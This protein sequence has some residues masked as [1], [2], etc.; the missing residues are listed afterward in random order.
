M[1][2]EFVFPSRKSKGSYSAY[3]AYV[4]N[5]P[6]DSGLQVIENCSSTAVIEG[7]WDAAMSFLRQCHESMQQEENDL[8]VTT[9]HIHS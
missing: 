3:S 1:V 7:E 6:P 2:F 4:E 8:G 9:V 5:L